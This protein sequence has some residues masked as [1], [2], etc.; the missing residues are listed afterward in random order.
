[1][2][3]GEQ[4][5]RGEWGEDIRASATPEPGAHSKP[6]AC[7]LD[8]RGVLSIWPQIR[9]T[10]HMQMFG[11]WA[12]VGTQGLTRCSALS[13]GLSMSHQPHARHLYSLWVG[14]SVPVQEQVGASVSMEEMRPF[15]LC[16][17]QNCGP[18]DGLSSTEAA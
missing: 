18:R 9:E 2:E 12:G 1:M 10:G 3:E 8:P 4:Q 14:P 17:V 15:P 5:N 11:L 16:L 7:V 13:P 6:C